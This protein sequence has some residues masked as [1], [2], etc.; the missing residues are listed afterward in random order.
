[1]NF[2][3]GRIVRDRIAAGGILAVEATAD[4]DDLDFA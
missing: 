1:M 4:K 2:T 3:V